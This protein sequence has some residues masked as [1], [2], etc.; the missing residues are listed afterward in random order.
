MRLLNERL[1]GWNVRLK[2]HAHTYMV[3]L[4]VV[5][6]LLAGFGAVGF[7]H[8][9]DSL[10]HVFWDGGSIDIAWI[11]SLPWWHVV[12]APAVG[13]LLVGLIVHYGAREA[14]GHGVPEV[15]EAVALRGGRIRPRVVAVKTLAS[16]I[17]LAS[18]G[19]V[20][21]EGPIV[22]IGAAIGST[23]GQILELNTRRMRTIAGCGAAAGIAAT[24]NA[25]IA[26][27]IFVV[28]VLLRDLR[29]THISPLVVASVV[30]TAVSHE[31]LEDTPAFVIPEYSLAT[32]LELPAY[33]LLG[34]LAAI[35]GAF[36]IRILYRSEDL[37]ESLPI[38]P[39]V[40]AMLGGAGVGAIA[41]WQP[42][43][44]GNGYEGI[45]AA[46]LETP[47]WTWF[48][49]LLVAKFVS[50]CLTLGT[51]GSG[52]VFA[53]SLVMGAMA[54]GMIGALANTMFPG[55][56]G[57]V[58]AYALVGMGA[59]V[60]ATTHAPLT[61]IIILFELTGDY[62][63][64]LPLMIA[65]ILATLLSSRLQPE[66]IYTMKLAR[67]GVNLHAGRDANV[68]RN[69]T[70]S[71]I[72]RHDFRS[73]PAGEP[74]LELLSDL[75]HDEE[76]AYFVMD[77]ERF[78]GVLSLH[79]LRPILGDIDGCKDLLTAGDLADASSR[80][81]R[82]DD[83][84]DAALARLQS[85]H[86]DVLPVSDGKDIIGALHME[87]IL[88][89][90]RREVFKR[91]M[92]QGMTDAFASDEHAIRAI[93][94]NLLTEIEAPARFHGRT[95]AD[96]HLRGRHRVSI[97]VVKRSTEGEEDVIVPG[98]ETVI[99]PGD[100]LLIIGQEDAVKRLATI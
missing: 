60:A 40:L 4:A 5:V 23:V 8:L 33:A 68:L 61:A 99:Q 53:P 7:R 18:G 81:L 27:L 69:L 41:L 83:T 48:A 13:G 34:L 14:K 37:F 88:A 3:V 89:S 72:M 17:C 91:D 65:C 51:G 21:R 16:G 47:V 15:M 11:R 50:V 19:S 2:E 36:F 96:L 52:G 77:G 100:Q 62:A 43:V 94:N 87:D 97:L 35:L 10:Q 73:L 25:P 71:E 93:G 75:A 24:F 55:A 9:V 12:L 32:P 6:G 85:Q 1:Q 44:L 86:R 67:R 56:V 78:Q 84:L 82:P 90:Y 26:G 66:S 42:E 74:L 98:A 38:H 95:L 76:P 45:E 54:G 59:M 22:Q 58:G 57:P 31:M 46:L 29:Y 70:V 39:G 28:E 30:A 20:G 79:D 64:I 63:I 80:P 49:L 92:A